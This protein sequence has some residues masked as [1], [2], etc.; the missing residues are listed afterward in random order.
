MVSAA[1]WCVGVGGKTAAIHTGEL[2]VILLRACAPDLP[3]HRVFVEPDFRHEPEPHT[4]PSSFTTGHTDRGS[5]PTTLRGRPWLP[6]WISAPPGCRRKRL[7]QAFALTGEKRLR[8][9][10]IRDKQVEGVEGARYHLDVAGHAGSA[11]S[12]GVG[13]VPFLEYVGGASAGP[14]RGKPKQ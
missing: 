14:R 9:F 10:G 6:R 13:E 2:E 3:A 1:S 11:E 4:R 8:H 5:A 12:L 7:P